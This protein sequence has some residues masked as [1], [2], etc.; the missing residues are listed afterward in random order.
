MPELLDKSDVMRIINSENA[1]VLCC[2][3][4]RSADEVLFSIASKIN[5]L[6]TIQTTI[7]PEVRHGRW[8]FG[9]SKTSCW[10]TCSVCCKSQSEQTAT[11]SY[12]PNCGADM[13]GGAENV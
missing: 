5:S 12:C 2:T 13:Q 3:R 11:F 7:E 1:V 4:L 10:M 9:S 8:I 6:Q